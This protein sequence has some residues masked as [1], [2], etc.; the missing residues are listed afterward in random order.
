MG[1]DQKRHYV[2]P[3]GHNRRAVAYMWAWSPRKKA[4]GYLQRTESV[5]SVC[6]KGE[7][8]W[9]RNT[10]QLVAEERHDPGGKGMD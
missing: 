1:E 3:G 8:W 9:G 4:H 7:S 2:S 10:R 5:S 6:F